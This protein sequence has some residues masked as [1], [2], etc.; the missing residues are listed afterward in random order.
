[1]VEPFT[2][3]RVA[4]LSNFARTAPRSVGR[5]EKL[6]LPFLPFVEILPALL[7][8]LLLEIQ[9]TPSTSLQDRAE[10]HYWAGLAHWRDQDVGSCRTHYEEPIEAYLLAGNIQGLAEVLV[11][12]PRPL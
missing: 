8:Q 6:T 1:M 9:R 7:N 11:E 3:D 10:L 4:R 2:P 5:R 12:K